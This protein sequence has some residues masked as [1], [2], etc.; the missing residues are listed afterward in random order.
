MIYMAVAVD[1]LHALLMVIWFIGL[2]LLFWWKYPKLSYYFCLYCVAFIIV[3]QVSHLILGECIFTTIANWFYSHAHACTVKD[4][5]FTI[6]ASRV[7]FG[8]VPT[9]RG[10]KIATQLLAGLTAVGGLLTMYK[11]RKEFH[12]KCQEP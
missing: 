9:H 4:E 8:A 12:K 11:I 3:N 5:W 6:R 7:V 10:I 1:V 2:P